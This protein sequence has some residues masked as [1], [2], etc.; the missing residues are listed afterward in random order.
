[1]I[2][3]TMRLGAAMT[4]LLALAGCDPIVGGACAP[5]AI[6]C[7]GQCVDPMHTPTACGGCGIRCADDEVCSAGSCTIGAGD[8][9][10]G[11]GGGLG[12][13]GAPVDGGTPVDGGPVDGGRDE[14]AGVGDGGTPVDGGA[15]VDGGGLDG[16][17]G[18]GGADGGM[19]GPC[20]LGE[21]L[22]ENACVSPSRDPS[23]C[24][25]CGNVCGSTELC[26]SGACV[27]SCEAPLV[28]CAGG[29]VDLMNTPEHCG[30]CGNVC[31]TGLCSEGMCERALAGHV[32]LIGHDFVERRNAMERLLANAVLLSPAATV[33]VLAYEGLASASSIAGV[34]GALSR[35]VGGAMTMTVATDPDLVSAELATADV[36]LIHAQ[37]GGSREQL[38]ALGILWSRAMETFLLRGGVVVV[39][40]TLAPHGGTWQLL[41]AAGRMAGDAIE[42]ATLTTARIVAPTDA[43]A[44]GVPLSYRAEATSVR[45]VGADLP[46]VVTDG[47]LPIVLH[48]T[49]TE[50][51]P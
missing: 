25:A 37:A 21:V 41:E 49:L 1:M 23:H 34:E 38:E 2:D 11:D 19:T 50:G 40:D 10:V 20:D 9:G 12:D 30:A 31:P 42:D 6:L 43:V 16:D 35:R 51:A 29:C 18:D 36:F 26:Q 47:A 33:R 14:D 15:P 4:L 5:S 48:G 3:S 39:L 28:A 7:D 27:P 44:I 17:A 8:A 32:V 45:F 13:G 46:V 22:C 24:G